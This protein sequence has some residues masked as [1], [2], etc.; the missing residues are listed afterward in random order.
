MQENYSSPDFEQK[1]T[2]P[3][4][5]LGA[6]WSPEAVFFRLWAPTAEKVSLRLFAG[7]TPGISDEIGHFP[8]ARDVQ[9]TWTVSLPGD[10]NGEY[11]TYLVT[12]DGTTKECCDPYAKATGV[13]GQR[14]MILDMASTD[15]EGWDQDSC[16]YRSAPITDHVIYE[17]HV[18]DLTVHPSSGITNKGKYLGLC[19]K[20]TS[21]PSGMATGLDHILDLGVTHVQLQPV[22]DFGSVDEVRELENQ[23]NWGY[24]PVNY[25]VPEGSFSTDPF[26]GH[27]RI[28]ELKTLIHTLHKN[29]LGVYMDVVYNH[30]FDRDT[31]CFNIA[32][33]GYFSRG[34]SNGSGCGNDTASERSMV[35]KYIID[36]LYHW[37]KEYHI[38]GF[39]FDL[40]GLIDTQT[41]REAMDTIH[42]THP[43]VQFYG[44][45]WHMD[46]LV[47]KQETKMTE[48]T[49]S[50]LLPEFGF[51]NDTFRDLLRGSV[52][53]HKEKGYLTGKTGMKNALRSCFMG[54]T[55]WA[56]SPSQNINYISCHDNHTLFDRLSL[57]LPRASREDIARR[58]RLG[59][60]FTLL[61]QG[62]P[63]LLAGEEMLR[64]KPSEDGGFDE[65]S[66][67]SPDS[68]NS[69]KWS[70]LDQPLFKD[71]FAYYKGLIR[72][73]KAHDFLRLT[74][75][76][77][78]TETIKA[79]PCADPHTLIFCA[80]EDC[81][82]AVI[83]FNNGTRES[84]YT[85]PEGRWE[86]YI[87]G[88]RSGTAPLSTAEGTVSIPPCSAMVFLQAKASATVDVVAAMI[89]K[90]DRIL[91]C[92][93]PAN[94]ARGL[95]W[96]FPG[97]KVE[98]GEAPE[99]ALARE[100]EEELGIHINVHQKIAQIEH[101]YPDIRIRLAL[102]DCGTDA[103]EIA[104]R[105]HEKV[106]WVRPDE[107]REYP[108]SPA[109]RILCNDIKP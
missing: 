53:E 43:Y 100:C 65:N 77:A 95:L 94:K 36:S 82:K 84:S 60:A 98:A 57:S 103:T 91:I 52:F 79:I 31:F 59:A 54:L 109:D 61:S 22:Y 87:D 68:V 49:N 99:A 64:S 66:Y 34:A 14:A 73:R 108:L 80:Q 101:E 23:Y 28:R 93:R 89:R 74:D 6:V 39:R 20:G 72:F 78:V 106:H 50:R 48:Q 18:R 24:D 75:R 32:V 45:G 27:T 88:S 16:V 70:D 104:P 8:M 86:L 38:D 11:Y 76:G 7:G 62:V 63:F 56:C 71:Q 9:G 19:E 55:P 5:D 92:Q 2:Y 26:N 51:F 107:I 85:L 13:N 29:G 81:E 46:S 30:V 96:E 83:I 25:N 42:Q 10:H 105:E 33:P 15:P 67:R 90:D 3:G 35:R 21:L 1:Y 40:A 4:T 44:E 58:C 12:H 17:V 37:V 102:Y 41:I 69:I 47:T 97:G